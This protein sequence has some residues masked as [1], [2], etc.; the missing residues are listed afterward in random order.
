MRAGRRDV[1]ITHPGKVLFP[2]DGIT[3][4]DLAAYY[5]DVAGWMI[6]HVRERPVSMQRFN[7]GISRDGFFQK[8][9]PRGAPDWLRRV[10]VTKRGGRLVHALADDAAAL[11]W[12]AN[13]NCITPHVWT[14]R[15]DR[16]DRPDR[17]IWDLDPAGDGHDAFGLVRRTALELGALLRELQVEPWAMTTGSRGVHVV[18]PVRRRYDFQAVHASARAVADE[19]VARRPDDLTTEFYVRKRAGRL[20]VDVNRNA[21]AATAVPPYAVRPRPGAPVA[22][23]LRWEELEDATLRAESFTL[24]TVLERPG[25]PWEQIA[26]S[27]GRLPA[28]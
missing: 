7:A 27:A 11:V 12:L 23:P 25:D 5:R 10:E 20:F 2:A 18:V 15:A 9:L 6:P 26:R 13:Q 4:G 21:R 14:S 22:T 17:M 16:L 8:N 3:K 1:T 19:L 24:R 28:A